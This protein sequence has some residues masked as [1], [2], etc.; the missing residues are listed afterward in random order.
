LRDSGVPVIAISPIVG[1]ESLKGP[2]KKMMHEMSVPTSAIWIAEH[3][4]DFVEGLVVDITDESL[5]S[6]IEATGVATIA[7]NIVMTSLDD[8]VK[9]AE[10]SLELIASLTESRWAKVV[11]GD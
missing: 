6:E 8:R 3:Y 9:L 10:T 4:R 1:G 5:V 7:T 11:P 2:L